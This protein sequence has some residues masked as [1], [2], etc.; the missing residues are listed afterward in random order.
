M[1][2]C[3]ARTS[4]ALGKAGVV[5]IGITPGDLGA[6]LEM[7]GYSNFGAPINSMISQ[8]IISKMGYRS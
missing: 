8:G 5:S 6:S 4:V 3:S 2:N 7:Q 1:D